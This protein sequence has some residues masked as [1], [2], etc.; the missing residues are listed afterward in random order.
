MIQAL[1]FTHHPTFSFYHYLIF[2]LPPKRKRP[3]LS[4]GFA[5]GF[6]CFLCFSLLFY[7]D[8]YYDYYYYHYYYPQP[9]VRRLFGPSSSLTITREIPFTPFS[10]SNFVYISIW[11]Y[12]LLVPAQNFLW[13]TSNQKR[14]D[15]SLFN[16]QSKLFF[17]LFHNPHPC[18][19]F[20][21]LSPCVWFWLFCFVFVIISELFGWGN[22]FLSLVLIS[23]SSIVILCLKL[24]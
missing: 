24:S 17:Y 14:K 22:F 18:G 23:F 12:I 13:N 8:Y 2:L 16:I 5:F 3:H 10:C 4:L 11:I 9:T 15:L 21:F 19:W 7:C 6:C 1:C 20:F